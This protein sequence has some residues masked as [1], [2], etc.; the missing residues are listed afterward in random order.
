MTGVEAVSNGVSAFRRPAVKYAH[1]TLTAIA[2]IL[3]FLVAAISYLYP[4][5]GVHAMDETQPGYQ[6]VPSQLTSAVVGQGVI[7]F[8]ATG[9]LLAVL[10]LSANTSFVDF[11]RLCRLVTRDGY[12]PRSFSHAGTAI[13]LLGR[14][15]YGW[16]QRPDCCSQF[17]AGLPTG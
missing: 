10:C 3:G 13:G 9:S 2:L 4:S 7:Y 17:S 14:R 15:H 11:P 12:L 8:I 5:Y 1:R 6:S 16:R